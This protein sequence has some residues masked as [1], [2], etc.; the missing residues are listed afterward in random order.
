MSIQATILKYSHHFVVKNPTPAMIP[1]LYGLSSKYTQFG[2]IFDPKT[3]KQRWG[4]L[5]TFA[6]YVQRGIEFRFHINQFQEFLRLIEGALVDPSS[7][8]IEDVELPE[9]TKVDLPI[10]EGWVLRPEQEEGKNFCLEITENAAD[11]P[12]LMMP[13]GTGK[14]VCA[15]TIASALGNRFAVVLLAQYVDKWISDIRAVMDIELNEIGVIKGSDSLIR[16]TYYPESGNPIPKAFVISLSTMSNWYKLYEEDKNHPSLEAYHCMPYDFFTHLGIGTVLFD[17]VHQHPHAVYRLYCYTNAKKT[18]SLSATLISKDQSLQRVQH[19]M[20]PRCK[21]FDSVKMEKYITAHACAYQIVN[22]TGS[23]LMISEYGRN[24]YSQAAYEKSLLRHKTIA[25]QYLTMVLDLIESSYIDGKLEGDK[26]AVFVGTANMAETLVKAITLKWP[27]L[28]TRT[29]LEKDD[30]RNVIDPDIRVTT[31]L[32]GGTAVDIPNL[33]VSIMT[34]S[35]DSPIS[36]IQCLGRLRKLKDRDVRF[37][38]L[39]CSTIPKQLEYHQKK[40]ELFKDR[41]TEVKQLFV[42]TLYP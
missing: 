18:I 31:I 42:G 20:F 33:R 19:M 8:T 40:L 24:S 9:P 1:M 11:S 15:L 37:Y 35:I 4:P 41:V 6:I 29:Y 3:R 13:T 7:Y 39:Y 14:T 32:S 30:Y 12:L 21:R 38:Y 5:K 2:F 10:R 27:W 25:K 26:L 28:D 36:N 22:F 34:N 17:E 23:R 16:T